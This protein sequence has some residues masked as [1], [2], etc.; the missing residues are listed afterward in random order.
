LLTRREYTSFLAGNDQFIPWEPSGAYDS[1]ATT[2]LGSST[3]TIT[4]SSIPSTYTHLQLRMSGISNAA[5][6]I[7]IAY[8]SDTTTSNY[9]SHYIEG[10]GS[11]AYAGNVTGVAGNTYYTQSSTQP[12][13][14]I[15]DILDYANTNKYKVQ[16]ALSGNDTNGG[17]TISM[18]SSLWLNTNAITS[19]TITV[20][21]TTFAANSSFALYGI[22][23]N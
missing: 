17:G 16:R 23:G 12:F 1:I 14:S 18:Y 19:L 8:N 15:V 13:S 4:F 20:T 7:C 6:R 3:A 11:T 21:T 22:K 2:T 5:N 9:N 10:N